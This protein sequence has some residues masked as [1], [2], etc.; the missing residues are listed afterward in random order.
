MSTQRSEQQP[1]TVTVGFAERGGR[2]VAY[3][4]GGSGGR[5]PAVR[6]GFT[7]RPLPALLGRDVAYAALEAVAGELLK[8]GVSRVVFRI[9]D[10][11]LPRDL[12]ERRSMPNALILPYVR[13]RCA[14]NRFAHASVEAAAGNVARDASARARADV[15]LNVA[16]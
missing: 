4:V 12:A 16:A 5:G 9:D 10:D 11:R 8:R 3:A 15:W 6:V 7:C 1:K 13:L 14:L 2:G